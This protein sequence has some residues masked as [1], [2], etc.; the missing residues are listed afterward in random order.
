MNDLTH[1]NKNG[2]PRMVDVSSKNPT[3]RKAIAS[4]CIRMEHGTLRRIRE[5]GV[6]KGDVLS[7]ASIAAVMGAKKAPELIPMCHPLLLSGVDVAFSDMEDGKGLRVEV[8]V[9]C[10]GRTGV[11]MEA[12]TS[13]SAALLA[14]YDM[15]KAIDKAMEITDIRLEEK[16]GGTSG[17]WSRQ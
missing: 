12:L 17:H 4:G 16:I 11:E 5:G 8:A 13:V 10:N 2:S 1:F 15:C 9:N 7:V 6:A 14:I 3:V